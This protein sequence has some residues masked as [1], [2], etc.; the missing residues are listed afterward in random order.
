MPLEEGLIKKLKE[1]TQS[2]EYLNYPFDK[3]ELDKIKMDLT[4]IKKNEVESPS[5]LA[6]GWSKNV[7]KM[8]PEIKPLIQV[9]KRYLQMKRLNSPFKGNQLIHYFRWIIFF[10]TINLVKWI[11]H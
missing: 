7:L 3:E 6:I 9:L 4:F 2:S 1:F 8:N 5:K 11:H 10:F